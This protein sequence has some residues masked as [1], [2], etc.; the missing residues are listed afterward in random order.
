MLHVAGALITATL[1][2][3][4]S[5]AWRMNIKKTIQIQFIWQPNHNK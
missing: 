4:T 5:V 3:I 1:I 2:G